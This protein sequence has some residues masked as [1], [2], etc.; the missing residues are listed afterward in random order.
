MVLGV[1]AGRR[2]DS[3]Q[4]LLTAWPGSNIVENVRFERLGALPRT[5]G[6]YARPWPVLLDPPGLVPRRPPKP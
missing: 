3:L 1:L 2:R 5:L 4:G 6:T